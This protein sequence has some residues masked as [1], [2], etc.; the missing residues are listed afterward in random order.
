[1]ENIIKYLKNLFRKDVDALIGDFTKVADKLGTLAE[2]LFTDAVR[3]EGLSKAKMAQ[4]AKAAKA[5]GNI[6]NLVS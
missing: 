3:L 1:M 2:E 4:S 5:A 6:K